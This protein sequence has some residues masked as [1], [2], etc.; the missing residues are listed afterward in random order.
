MT[1]DSKAIIKALI[2]GGF[3]PGTPN[4]AVPTPINEP[5]QPAM[6]RITVDPTPRLRW[7]VPEGEEEARYEFIVEIAEDEEFTKNVR[8]YSSQEDKRPFSFE[9]PR[10]AN[11]GEIV[12]IR[13]PDPL[14]TEDDP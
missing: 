9:S 14:V 6:K 1:K 4:V 13:V 7:Q 2:G 12:H 3:L 10:E 5:D 11:S 8:R